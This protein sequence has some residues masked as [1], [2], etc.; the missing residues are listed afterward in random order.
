MACSPFHECLLYFFPLSGRRGG[1]SPG[2]SHFLPATLLP[3]FWCKI[4]VRYRILLDFAERPF[5][6]DEDSCT[7]GGLVR[8]RLRRDAWCQIRYPFTNPLG[9]GPGTAYH[10]L[11]GACLKA[12]R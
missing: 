9:G 8:S 5:G 3:S 2:V 4:D 12:W 6:A 10:A 1:F 7:H 11:N